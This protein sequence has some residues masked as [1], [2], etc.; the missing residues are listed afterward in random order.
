[1][2]DIYDDVDKSLFSVLEREYEIPPQIKTAAMD[3]GV[4]EDKEIF[5]YP[6]QNKYPMDTVQ[7]LYTSYLYFQKTASNLPA[8]AR[9]AV[10]D[11][12]KKFANLCGLSLDLQKKEASEYFP[13]SREDFALAIPVWNI[14]DQDLLQKA[15]NMIHDDY[16]LLYPIDTEENIKLANYY[17]PASL[18]GPLEVFR[19]K[20]ARAIAE[21]LDPLEYSDKLISYLPIPKSA[22]LDQLEARKTSHPELAEKYA[23]LERFLVNCSPENSV[24]FANELEKLDKTAN[25]FHHSGIVDA[26]EFRK[27]IYDDGSRDRV[28]K[29][30]NT[31]VL[32]SD[33]LDASNNISGIV[34]DWEFARQAPAKFASIVD[35]LPNVIQNHILNKINSSG[36]DAWT[37]QHLNRY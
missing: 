6:E 21:R 5:A 4:R 25:L 16:L 32:W 9:T 17:F 26:S 31:E 29:I 18:N 15:A 11:N 33:V 7:D 37:A 3:S 35:E 13:V 2:F 8:Y 30:A 23:S 14:S 28:V 12:F 20:V 10:E 22:A 36:H 19:P 34:P 1:M 27:L 24:K